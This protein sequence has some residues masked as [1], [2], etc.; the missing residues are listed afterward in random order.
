MQIIPKILL[1]LL[2]F[3]G[4]TIVA[5]NFFPPSEGLFGDAVGQ[6]EAL[7]QDSVTLTAD[8]KEMLAHTAVTLWARNIPGV[9]HAEVNDAKYLYLFMADSN[10]D[11][12]GEAA[13][14]CAA[15]REQGIS[16]I[17]GVRIMDEAYVRAGRGFRELGRARC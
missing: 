14:V 9:E 16:T 15:I 1:A 17:R 7:P 4:G 12:T 6:S 2:L 3:L 8:E 10:G 13:S 11:R 5:S